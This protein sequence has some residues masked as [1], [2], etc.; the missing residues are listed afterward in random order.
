M[1]EFDGIMLNLNVMGTRIKKNGTLFNF[2]LPEEVFPDGTYVKCKNCI[3]NASRF[4]S[5]TAHC[6]CS[7]HMEKNRMGSCYCHMAL[8]QRREAILAIPLSCY[9]P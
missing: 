8:F 9:S 7:F 4:T 2:S 6:R 1:D 3:I 5:I